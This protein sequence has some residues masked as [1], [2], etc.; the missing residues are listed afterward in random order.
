M[1]S[2]CESLAEITIPENVKSIGDMSFSLCES[3]SDITLPESVSVIGSGAFL[4]CTSLKKVT[5]ENPNCKIYDSE[6]TIPSTAMIYCHEN[7]TAKNYINSYGMDY[8]IIGQPE[9]ILGDVS[10]DLLIDS[11]D[12]SMLLAEYALMQT[13]KESSLSEHQKSAADV[14][15]DSVIDSADASKIMEYYAA[16]STGQKPPW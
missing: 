1:F 2:W 14:N 7:S 3:L 16:L 10:E 15:G 5:I 13:G 6:D 4:D 9:Y 12:A 11:V 8:H